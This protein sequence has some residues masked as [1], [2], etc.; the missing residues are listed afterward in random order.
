MASKIPDAWRISLEGVRWSL[1]GYWKVIFDNARGTRPS[2]AIGDGTK[3]LMQIDGGT[4]AT[5][6]PAS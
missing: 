4:E 1:Y 5:G 3:L 2:R 6:D